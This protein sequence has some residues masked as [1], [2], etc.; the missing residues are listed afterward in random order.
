V[1][2]AILADP[3]RGQLVSVI[4]MKYWWYT[5]DGKAFDP[6]G[7]ENLAPR[8]QLREWKGS[9]KRT[10]TSVARQIREYRLKYP[11]KA[12]TCSLDGVSGWTVAAAGGSIA[13]LPAGTDTGL[14]AALT[15]MRP[16]GTGDA[17]TLT[18]PGRDYLVYAP[19]G[20]EISLDLTDQAESFIARWVD[21][22]A[23]RAAGPETPVIGGK[24]FTI[25]PSHSGPALLWVTR[26]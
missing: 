20:G 13:N 24:T 14:R 19:N 15:R 17:F 21:P 6:N 1:Q 4:D 9:S 23:G 10:D 11:D 16:A 2:D 8:Q 3:V 22:R 26:K 5:A 7:G 12:V 18:D 25:T